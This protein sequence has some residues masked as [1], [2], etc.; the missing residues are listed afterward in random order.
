MEIVNGQAVMQTVGEVKKDYIH[1]SLF[2]YIGKPLWKRGL[3]AY[4]FNNTLERDYQAFVAKGDAMSLSK[5]LLRI[6]KRITKLQN[7]EKIL[8][9]TD[10]LKRC[11]SEIK[12]HL[13]R[14]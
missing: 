7:S 8:N 2:F 9:C 5:A 1:P 14:T 6:Q 3:P 12:G 11:I 10:A 4:P 13:R